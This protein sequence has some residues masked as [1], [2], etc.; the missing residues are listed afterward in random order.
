[1]GDFVARLDAGAMPF[2]VSKEADVDADSHPGTQSIITVG[3][4]EGR[5]GLVQ[6]NGVSKGT[7]DVLAKPVPIV[8]GPAGFVDLPAGDAWPQLGFRQFKHFLEMMEAFPL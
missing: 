8:V 1:M 6:P 4:E 2:R 7:D 3:S 5:L